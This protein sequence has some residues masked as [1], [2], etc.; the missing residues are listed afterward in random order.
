MRSLEETGRRNGIS[1]LN[2]LH[3]RQSLQVRVFNLSAHHVLKL[4]YIYKQAY[5]QQRALRRPPLRKIE[6]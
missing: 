6:L 3:S 5:I 1:L 4:I 2:E